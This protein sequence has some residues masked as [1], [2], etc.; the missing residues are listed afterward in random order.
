MTDDSELEFDP[1]EA[2]SLEKT[3]MIVLDTHVLL[4]WTLE[5][6][7]LSKPAQRAIDEAETLGVPAVI[8]WE[9]ALL[10]RKRRIKLGV[11]AIEWTRDV[12]T[13]QRINALALT[14]KIAVTAESLKMHPDLADRFI[15]ATAAHHNAALVT[16]DELIRSAKLVTTIW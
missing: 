4:W 13:L 9:V 5:T 6:E 7:R 10:A 16:R 14:P 1:L 3:K 12:L 11:S 8:F 2:H 15:V